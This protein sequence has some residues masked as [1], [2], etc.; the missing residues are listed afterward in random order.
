MTQLRKHAFLTARGFEYREAGKWK[1]E[2]FS[3]LV[4]LRLSIAESDPVYARLWSENRAIWILND[5]IAQA[6]QYALSQFS[7]CYDVKRNAP[8]DDDGLIQIEGEE[9]DFRQE[10]ERISFKPRGVDERTKDCQIFFPG[11]AENWGFS[12]EDDPEVVERALVALQEHFRRSLVYPPGRLAIYLMEGCRDRAKEQVDYKKTPRFSGLPVEETWSGGNPFNRLDDQDW[13]KLRSLTPT[14]AQR[15]YVHAFDKNAAFLQCVGVSLPI[16]NYRYV[17]K[18]HQ[19]NLDQLNLDQCGLWLVQGES[20][21]RH[22][23]NSGRGA[24][25]IPEMFAV[26]GLQGTFPFAQW[27]TTP[28]L[29]LLCELDLIEEVEEAYLCDDSH[30]LFPTYYSQVKQAI[31]LSYLH[32]APVARMMRR[33]IKMMYVKGVGY[34][35]ASFALEAGEWFYRPDWWATIVSEASVRMFRDAIEVYQC[36]GAWPIAAYIDCLYYVSDNPDRIE[37]F[38][39]FG[40]IF[41]KR[42][43]HKGTAPLTPELRDAAINGLTPGDFSGL[44]KQAAEAYE[45]GEI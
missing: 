7:K 37:A 3:G 2:D 23:V 44:F 42:Y 10:S 19:V 45:Q 39:I 9:D 16:G 25:V 26:S 14:E 33:L 22:Q 32:D 38:P 12:A 21:F 40:R 20:Y 36:E 17:Y 30:K 29:K 4:G 24:E 13:K 43:K 34:L 28:T 11:K 31:G 6:L 1:I 15:R 35:C 41:G 8:R 5:G 27:V 18:P